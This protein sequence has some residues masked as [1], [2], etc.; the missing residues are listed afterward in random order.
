MIFLKEIVIV[1]KFKKRS[2]YSCQMAAKIALR[3]I[4]GEEVDTLLLDLLIAT[5]QRNRLTAVFQLN[6]LTNLPLD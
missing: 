6:C 2:N 5:E 4:P 3:W 1:R